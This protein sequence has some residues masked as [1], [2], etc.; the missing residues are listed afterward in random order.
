[1]K[2][3]YCPIRAQ[4]PWINKDLIRNWWSTRWKFRFIYLYPISSTWFGRSFR[5]T[6]GALDRIYSFWYSPPTLLLAV[7]MDLVHDTVRQQHRWTISEA[8]NT[9]SCSWW[10]EKA[11]PETCRADW[12]QI[13][14]PNLHLIGH[15]LRN[16]LMMQGH[17]NT[18]KKNQR[19]P[20]LTYEIFWLLAGESKLYNCLP[21]DKCYVF[22]SCFRYGLQGDSNN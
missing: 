20:T 17:T 12:V 3:F 5:P 15:Q 6:S 8:I 19:L 2:N 14:K 13:N 1:M 10:W 22:I 18:Q 4:R 21:P 7:V 16:I 9:V 11:S